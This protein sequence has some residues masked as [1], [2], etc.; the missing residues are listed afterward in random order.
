[1]V[2]ALF[3]AILDV[4]VTTESRH[5]NSSGCAAETLDAKTVPAASLMRD[6]KRDRPKAVKID[7]WEEVFWEH[8]LRNSAAGKMFHAIPARAVSATGLFF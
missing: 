8:R 3:G 4:L 2:F 6:S 7:E 1:L 5:W